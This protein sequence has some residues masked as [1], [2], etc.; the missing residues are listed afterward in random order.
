MITHV[1]DMT[2]NN[3]G[4]NTESHDE[5]ENEKG[6]CYKNLGEKFT[7]RLHVTPQ[8]HLSNMLQIR[9]IVYSTLFTVH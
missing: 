3:P 9:L 8:D 7:G 4:Q 1:S 5:M 2:S 6:G